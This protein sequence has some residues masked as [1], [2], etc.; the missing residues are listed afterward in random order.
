LPNSEIKKTILLTTDTN[1][2]TI[3]TPNLIA[4]NSVQ[5][6]ADFLSFNQ[7][8]IPVAVLLEGRFTSLFANRLSSGL[9][10]SLQNTG[11]VFVSKGNAS[12][13]QIVVADADLFTNATEQDGQ[14]NLQPLPMGMLPFDR[15]QFAN[16]NFYLN[17]I[18]YL[19]DPDGLLESR[20]KI[21]VLRLLDRDK[22]ENAKLIWQIVLVLGPLLLLTCFYFLW[23]SIRKSKFT[24]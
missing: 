4:I 10:D 1:S 17:S 6:E 15:Y 22:L 24:T 21:L 23:N 7:N 8:H 13:K 5:E 11:S 12:A 19:N 3:T 20:N 14:G 18:A 9:S 16:R 2:R